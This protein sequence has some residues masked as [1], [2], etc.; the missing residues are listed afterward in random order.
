V[1]KKVRIEK[2]KE[3]DNKS[4]KDKDFEARA[5]R[6]CDKPEYIKITPP[7]NEK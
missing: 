1:K 5:D 7:P 4:K 2:A 3:K 6:F